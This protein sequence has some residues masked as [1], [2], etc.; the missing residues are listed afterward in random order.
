MFPV[1]LP[2]RAPPVPRSW[3]GSGAVRSDSTRNCRAGEAAGGRQMRARR[4]TS[5]RRSDAGERG[6]QR[7]VCPNMA[8]IV[9]RL[10]QWQAWGGWA[11]AGAGAGA[12][13]A[14]S[15]APAATGHADGG[16]DPTGSHGSRCC[17]WASPV[18]LSS[19]WRMLWD[20][21]QQ[22]YQEG[23]MRI[24]MAGGAGLSSVG[25]RPCCP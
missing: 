7:C 16:R 20:R 19:R 25:D 1:P 2:A 18:S 5:K 22:G 15:E 11:G 13:P 12:A 24:T 23:G 3:A 17:R 10:R 9:S 14:L 4:E 6:T 21:A 8:K